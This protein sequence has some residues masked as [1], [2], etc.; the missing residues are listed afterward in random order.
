VAIYQEFIAEFM[1][2]MVDDLKMTESS[3]EYPCPECSAG[4]LPHER[5]M[6]V[7]ISR[8]GPDHLANDPRF[9]EIMAGGMARAL[10]DEML[11]RHL[12]R[13]ERSPVDQ[14]TGRFEV[15]ATIGVMAPGR[16]AKFEER[17]AERQFEVAEAIVVA[18]EEEVRNWGSYYRGRTGG[19]VEKW[20]AIEWLQAALKKVREKYGR[21]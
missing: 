3:R 12:I 1:P 6:A 21:K 9:L 4:D 20:Q 7:K 8:D 14:S 5:L 13:F 11:K 17:V 16:V 19:S 18:A 15:K 2:S 10:G